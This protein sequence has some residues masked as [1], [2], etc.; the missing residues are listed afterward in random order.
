MSKSL[1]LS[2]IIYT[3][4]LAI[5]AIGACIF[6]YQ[7]INKVEFRELMFDKKGWME[8]TF[9]TRGHMAHDILKKEM[10]LGHSR[11]QITEL[12]GIADIERENAWYYRIGRM[13]TADTW[14]RDD[15]LLAIY[16]DIAGSV[17]KAYIIEDFNS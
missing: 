2:R 11:A 13:Q 17:E 8:S 12:L 7:R 1:S 9:Q 14:I 6:L 4:L 5:V 3:T 10:L 16:F 15:Y